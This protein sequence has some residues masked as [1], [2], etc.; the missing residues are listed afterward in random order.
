M[1]PEP[2]AGVH[3]VLVFDSSEASGIGHDLVAQLHWI[4][5]SN[6]DVASCTVLC[7][8]QSGIPLVG[9][10]AGGGQFLSDR[11][12]VSTATCGGALRATLE[13]I[14]Q[15]DEFA[16]VVRVDESDRAVDG[17]GMDPA[18]RLT[19][20]YGFEYLRV[21]PALDADGVLRAVIHVASCLTAVLAAGV[22]GGVAAGVI[23]VAT[24]RK[25]M[26]QL[27]PHLP[28]SKYLLYDVEG[29]VAFGESLQGEAG[30]VPGFVSG[31]LVKASDFMLRMETGDED[32]HRLV[33]VFSPA[34]ERFRL[35]T[36]SREIPWTDSLASMR[37]VFDRSSM[38]EL[39]D[40]IA[41]TFNERGFGLRIATP[42]SWSI[43]GHDSDVSDLVYPCLIKSRAACGV[44]ESHQMALVLREEGMIEC[45]MEGQLVAQEF[46]NHGGVLF[47]VYVGRGGYIVNRRSSLPDIHTVTEEMPSII[48]FD[49]LYGLPTRLPWVASGADEHVSVPDEVFTELV[50]VARDVV[51][52]TVFGFD[53][54]RRGDDVVIVDINYLPRLFSGALG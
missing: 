2:G 17:A 44:P 36:E 48:E 35:L 8:V 51:R 1:T 24:S 46:I 39:M 52:L 34:F 5:H 50:A 9:S 27:S 41:A 19:M 4:L 43:L 22:D 21:L 45:E 53:V 12:L 6:P 18:K 54:V 7:I 32:H 28:F 29:D 23:L 25:R 38:A 10:D 33:P 13:M 31:A 14:A 49:S 47:K 42:R 40:A 30:P 37:P 16:V 20:A 26:L 11:R 15:R 3:L